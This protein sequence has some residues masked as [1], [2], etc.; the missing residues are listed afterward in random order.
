MK[1]PLWEPTVSQIETSQMTVFRR[2]VN[3]RF[4]LNLS[5]YTAFWSWSI[6]ENGCFWECL[7]DFFDVQCCGSTQ[8]SIVNK[9]AMPGAKWFPNIRLNFAKNLLRFHD[10]HPAIVFWNEDGKQDELS[11]SELYAE[12][13]QVVC[14]LQKQGV[15]SGDRVAAYMPNLPQ[16]IVV[17][18]AAASLGA[19]FTS[20]SPDFG[21]DAIADRFDQVQPVVLVAADGWKYNGRKH[22]SLERINKVCERVPTI[23]SVLLVPYISIQPQ[24]ETL[25]S[26]TEVRLTL[27]NELPKPTSEIGWQHLPFDHPLYILFSSGTTG[28]P[29]CIVHGVGGTLLQHLKEHRLHTNITRSD[30]F[31]YFTTC[32]WMMWNWLASGLASGCTL[33]LYDGSPMYAEGEILF[34]LAE[35]EKMTVFGTSAKYLSAVEKAGIHPN[36]SHDLSSLRTVL[37]TGSPLSDAS[38]EFVYKHI[39]RDVCLSSISGGTD[40]VSCFALGNPVLPVWKAELQCR[41]LG[42]AVDV[43][44]DSGASVRQQK[45]ELVCTKPFPSMPISFWNDSTGTKYNSAY[46]ERF[47]NVWCHGDY[48]ELTEHDGV[49][50]YGRSDAVLNP[51]GV[52]IG[53]AEI[54]RLVEQSPE[55]EES[56]VIGQSWKEDERIILFVRLAKGLQLDSRLQEEIRANIR[57]GATARHVP[58]IILQVPEMPRTKSGKLVELAVRNIVNKKPV[59]N[60]YVLQNPEALHAFENRVELQ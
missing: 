26:N 53:T 54:Y 58:A 20:C 12:V 32:G 47:P 10:E 18:L 17:M 3:E 29:K 13:S 7:F 36:E 8:P 21:V 22:S 60:R 2:Y 38:Y 49:V 51:G 34:D 50:I 52:R 37:S 30:R 35:K 48:C 11:Y 43:F 14:W 1:A 4:S 55:I 23:Q 15:Q 39:S 5:D 42:M 46:F 25:L 56:L 9:A 28:V 40:I 59:V 33:L 24:H 57:N 16:T 45:G 19:V 6:E 31:F 27:W 41:G 44:D